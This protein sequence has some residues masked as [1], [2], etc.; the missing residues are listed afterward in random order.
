MEGNIGEEMWEM[1]EG[2]TQVD[3]RGA[4]VNWGFGEFYLVVELLCENVL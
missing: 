1:R 2:K 4:L 3:N